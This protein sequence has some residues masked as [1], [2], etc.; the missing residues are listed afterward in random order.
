[1]VG[2]PYIG[3]KCEFLVSFCVTYGNCLDRSHI[4]LKNYSLPLA[5]IYRINL[6]INLTALVRRQAPASVRSTRRESATV[7][8][9][10]STAVDVQVSM[11]PDLSQDISTE[12]ST[13][14]E[15]MEIKATP[16]PMAQK[17]EMKAKIL[18]SSYRTFSSVFFCLGDSA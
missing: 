12:R 16:V 7:H 4:R 5:F 15:I 1:M 17:K 6:R 14:E 8:R 13:W 18:V 3:P 11:M 10:T 2:G 9:R